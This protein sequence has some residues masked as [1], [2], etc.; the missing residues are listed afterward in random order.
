MGLDI[1][2]LYSLSPRQFYNIQKGFMEK[3]E[4]NA[5]TSWEQTRKLFFAVL[6]P[7]LKKA[8]IKENELMPF[9]WDVEEGLDGLVSKSDTVEDIEA[10]K[11]RWR[12]R[13]EQKKTK[14]DG[15]ISANKHSI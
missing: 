2:Y 15:G 9:P 8:T 11:E 1:G 4:L 10:V 6:K 13:D 12:L 3:E 7:H 14:V 5:K